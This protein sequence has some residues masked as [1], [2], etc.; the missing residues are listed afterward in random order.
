[1][2]ERNLGFESEHLQRALNGLPNVRHRIDHAAQRYG[3]IMN[4]EVKYGACTLLNNML[5]EQ[6]VNVAEP[7]L[8]EDPEGNRRRL[9]EQMSIYSMQFKAAQ[10]A[11]GWQ[12]VALSGKVGDMKDDVVICLQLGIYYSK[13]PHLYAA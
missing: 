9:K 1:M 5:R 3:V 4:E 6:R 11:F 13:Q 10:N 8:S 7:L 2:C 12:R